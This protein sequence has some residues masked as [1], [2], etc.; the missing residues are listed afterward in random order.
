M[1]GAYVESILLDHCLAIE[2]DSGKD[3][4]VLE[5]IFVV[6]MVHVYKVVRTLLY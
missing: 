6:D 5:A 3:D 1:K 4:F 2:S